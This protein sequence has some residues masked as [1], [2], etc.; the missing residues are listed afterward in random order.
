MTI[1]YK[2]CVIANLESLL[3]L[4]FKHSWSFFFKIL[5]FVIFNIFKFIFKHKKSAY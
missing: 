1:A 5:K 3:I 2:A 4:K